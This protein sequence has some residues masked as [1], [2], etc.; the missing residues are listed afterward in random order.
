MR[1]ILSKG[2]R[3]IHIFIGEYYEYFP[4]TFVRVVT[5]STALFKMSPYL[6][7]RKKENLDI[8]SKNT[9]YSLD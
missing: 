4:K 8:C 7:F 5:N 3:Q 2:T 6:P 1:N 9:F